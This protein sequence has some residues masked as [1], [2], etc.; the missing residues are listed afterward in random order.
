MS[1][2]VATVEVENICNE[3]LDISATG[4]AWPKADPAVMLDRVA[5]GDSV[6]ADRRAVAVDLPLH[7]ALEKRRS[8]ELVERIVNADVTALEAPN[9]NG[10]LP[11]EMV[12]HNHF[13]P[14]ILKL[15]LR[16]NPKAA[17][18]CVDALKK[19]LRGT[20]TKVPNETKHAKEK[21]I[22]DEREHGFIFTK[23]LCVSEE[24]SPEAAASI[25]AHAEEALT[26]FWE[27]VTRSVAT[28]TTAHLA[29]DPNWLRDVLQSPLVKELKTQK[30]D[31]VQKSEELL[32]DVK[33]MTEEAANGTK[34]KFWMLKARRL[35]EAG[36]EL[37]EMPKFQD[38]LQDRK[39]ADWL[40]LVE[41]S[42][43]DACERKQRKEHLAV[44]HCWETPE[45]PDMNKKPFLSFSPCIT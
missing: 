27:S 22:A 2:S 38:L 6:D 26:V 11:L 35:R 10:K 31:V 32:E 20:S 1:S 33:A 21:R 4:G 9:R 3:L 44:S 37:N 5:D 39:R 30:P 28:E 7:T 12:L 25:Q 45:H 36:H 19:Y 15:L 24:A 42:L 14:D 17:G 8:K 41:V 18:R 43:R 29:L 40:E 23:L 13:D 16:R 34:C